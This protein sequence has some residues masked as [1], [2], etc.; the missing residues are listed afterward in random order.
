VLVGSGEG[1]SVAVG[2][3]TTTRV[4]VASK[5]SANVAVNS[6]VLVGTG[7]VAVMVGI[8]GVGRMLAMAFKGISGLK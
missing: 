8:A 2:S 3:T 5:G 1:V 7:I 4:W 6:I